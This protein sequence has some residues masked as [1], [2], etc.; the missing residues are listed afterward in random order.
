MTSTTKKAI[1]VATAVVLGTTL[2]GNTDVQAQTRSSELMFQTPA[3]RECFYCRGGGDTGTDS[4]IERLTRA[5][6]DAGKAAVDRIAT[7]LGSVSA[8][9]I[10]DI[11]VNNPNISDPRALAASLRDRKPR[12]TP[13]PAHGAGISR[14]Y[15]AAEEEGAVYTFGMN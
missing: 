3:Q 14:A 10:S 12:R 13:P 9:D 7:S 6:T 8:L 15:E 4:V 11:M 1:L 2:L 5:I